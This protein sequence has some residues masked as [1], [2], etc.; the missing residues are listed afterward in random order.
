MKKKTFRRRWLSLYEELNVKKKVSLGF[1][2]FFVFRRIIYVQTGFMLSNYP[3]QQLQVLLLMNLFN[4]IYIGNY[5]PMISRSRNRFEF[6]N[7][8]CV[9]LVTCHFL[10]FSDFVDNQELQY[11]IGFS[12]IGFIALNI[13]INMSVVVSNVLR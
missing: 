2:L 5:T 13:M 11:L 4:Q 12:C 10:F 1:N 9:Y 8:I 6:F 3:S 7:D